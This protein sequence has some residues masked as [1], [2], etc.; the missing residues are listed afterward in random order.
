MKVGDKVVLRKFKTN[1]LLHFWPQLEDYVGKE[2][3]VN[4]VSDSDG[5]FVFDDIWWL[6]S[7]CEPCSEPVKTKRCFLVTYLSQTD[8]GSL[9]I[10]S[11]S[12]KMPSHKEMQKQICELLKKEIK[13]GITNIF[14]FKSEQD[15]LDFTSNE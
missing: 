1:P 12:G 9:T 5:T 14:E 10:I 2:V 11:G 7:A 3:V 4:E 15:F 6:Q 8:N 13:I